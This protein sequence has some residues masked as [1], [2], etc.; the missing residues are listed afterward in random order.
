MGVFLCMGGRGGQW[1]DLRGQVMLAP[2]GREMGRERSMRKRSEE[3]RRC[4]VEVVKLSFGAFHALEMRI[5]V[6]KYS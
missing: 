4:R 1:R 2:Q 5:L 3:M 6:E